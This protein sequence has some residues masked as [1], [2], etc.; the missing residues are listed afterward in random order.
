MASEQSPDG[1]GTTFVATAALAL[2]PAIDGMRAGFLGRGGALSLSLSGVF[3]AAAVLLWTG[4]FGQ[5]R[6]RRENAVARWLCRST[7][8]FV[9]GQLF[10]R[11]GVVLLLAVPAMWLSLPVVM[12]SVLILIGVR[13]WTSLRAAGN[14]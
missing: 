11:N 6:S 14:Q 13:M 10:V 8:A 9:I 4:A 3:V 12:A 7:I 1:G 2:I 5:A